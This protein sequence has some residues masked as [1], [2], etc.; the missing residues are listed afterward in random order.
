MSP[1]CSRSRRHFS[2]VALDFDIKG[3]FSFANSFAA[4][5]F[6]L[7]QCRGPLLQRSPNKRQSRNRVRGP[8]A[9]LNLK[10]GSSLSGVGCGES[11][12]QLALSVLKLGANLSTVFC[13][14][15]HFE[16]FREYSR[17]QARDQT[18]TV[19]QPSGEVVNVAK[20]KFIP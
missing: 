18:T 10:I 1:L 14:A 4:L 17:K 3:E 6:Y 19:N 20:R 9:S 8:A 7:A 5:Q 15:N 11:N 13:V 16:S 12:F 2:S